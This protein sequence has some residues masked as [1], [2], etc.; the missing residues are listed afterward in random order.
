MSLIAYF[1][2]SFGNKIRFTIFSV[3]DDIA[4]MPHG[5]GPSTVPIISAIEFKTLLRLF[6][7]ICSGSMQS[8]GQI[9][10]KSPPGPNLH[11]V[12]LGFSNLFSILQ[13]QSI[14]LR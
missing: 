6:S 5:S 12:L 13:H 7:D 10:I 3:P 4:G 11:N 2:F 1:N 14:Y 8:P 9:D